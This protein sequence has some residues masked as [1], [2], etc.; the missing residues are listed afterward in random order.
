MNFQ[1]QIAELARKANKEDMES[2]DDWLSDY[3]PRS[4]FTK[5]QISKTKKRKLNKIARKSRKVNQ[6]WAKNK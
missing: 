2:G 5:K 4:L 6:R 3:R 1:E